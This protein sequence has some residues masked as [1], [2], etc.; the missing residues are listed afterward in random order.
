MAEAAALVVLF[1]TVILMAKPLVVREALLLADLLLL[2]AT[3]IQHLLEAHFQVFLEQLAEM[4]VLEDLLNRQVAVAVAE[5]EVM[6]LLLAMA[7]QTSLVV[8]VRRRVMA[9]RV[10]LRLPEPRAEKLVPDYRLTLT[11]QL[12]AAQV[13]EEPFP[14]LVQYQVQTLS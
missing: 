1:R 4:E 6:S 13:V 2:G 7:R 10:A 5:L 3:I 11:L 14:S 12:Q 8:Q 9:A